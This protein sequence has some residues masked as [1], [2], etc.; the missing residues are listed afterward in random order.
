MQTIEINVSKK[1]PVVIGKDLLTK[2]GLL[3]GSYVAPCR[4]VLVSDDNVAPLYAQTVKESYQQAGYAVEIF[5]FPS[6][7]EQKTLDTVQRLLNFLAQKEITR[8][9]LLVALGGGVTGDLSGFAAA[10][11]LRGIRWIQIPTTLL[12]AVDASVGGK[13]GVDLPSGKNLV[14]AFYQPNAVFCDVKTFDTLPPKVYA[15]GICEVIKYG[16]I[17]SSTLFNTLLQDNISK[18]IEDVVA[19]CVDIKRQIVEQDEYDSALR[20]IL[21][22]G[23]TAGHAIERLSNYTVSHGQ[24]VAMGMKIMTADNPQITKLLDLVF[25]KY[26]ID[27]SC[28]YSADQLAQAAATDKKRSGSAITLVTLEKIGKAILQKIPL[29]DLRDVF[30]K[31]LSV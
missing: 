28:P 18:N 12:A 6:G 23:H 10:I 1:Y 17:S 31:G 16:C 5:T 11:Y 2:S 25:Q 22:F 21:N 13:T 15:D 14:G 29:T 27:A 8:G 3:T 20:Q 4:M 9:D 30:A 24:A 19:C 26:N 7:E